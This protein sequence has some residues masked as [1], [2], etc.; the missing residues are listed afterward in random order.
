MENP[1]TINRFLV[2]L[3][4]ALLVAVGAAVVV[5]LIRGRSGTAREAAE[6]NLRAIDEFKRTNGQGTV[7][8]T[9]RTQ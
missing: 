1:R 7:T 3:V 2:A 8:E 6:K 5:S 9:R 4:A